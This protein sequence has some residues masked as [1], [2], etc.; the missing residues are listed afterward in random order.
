MNIFSNAGFYVQAFAQG[1]FLDRIR[2]RFGRIRQFK[3][4]NRRFSGA[5]SRFDN[6]ETQSKTP[7]MHFDAFR[8]MP[9][10]RTRG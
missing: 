9:Q 3:A 5:K 7:E 10:A 8:I 6:A 2:C 1:V 4:E